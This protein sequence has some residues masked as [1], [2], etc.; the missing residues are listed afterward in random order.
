VIR[1]YFILQS[2]Q[3]NWPIPSPVDKTPCPLSLKV[4]QLDLEICAWVGDN[5]AITPA[6]WSLYAVECVLDIY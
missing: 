6:S 5:K 2:I 1:D 3:A 4:R